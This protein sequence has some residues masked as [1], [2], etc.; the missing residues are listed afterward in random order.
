MLHP[1]LRTYLFREARAKTVAALL[2]VA[3][4]SA[5]FS[6]VAMMNVYL[7]NTAIDRDV[8]GFL[9]YLAISM[10]LLL[11]TQVVGYAMQRLQSR[12]RYGFACALRD[13]ATAVRLIR[14]TLDALSE[15]EGHLLNRYTQD[16]EYVTE[17]GV[18]QFFQLAAGMM[19][20]VASLAAAVWI[21]WVYAIIFPLM[22]GLTMLVPKAFA[23]KFAR[24][25]E[26]YS[27]ARGTLMT[28]LKDLIGGLAIYLRANAKTRFRQEI[29]RHSAEFETAADAYRKKTALYQSVIQGCS[30]FIQVI[31]IIATLVLILYGY[32]T[33]GAIVGLLNLSQSIYSS[34][35][36]LSSSMSAMGGLPPI[37]ARILPAEGTQTCSEEIVERLPVP[38]V[39]ASQIAFSYGDKPVLRDLS[40][41]IAPGEKVAIVGPSG[42]GKSTLLKILL[43]EL[44]PQ[45][46]SIELSG[47][48]LAALSPAQIYETVGFVAQD[49][50]LFNRSIRENITLGED[51]SE[52]AIRKAVSR[53]RLEDFLDALPSGLD[54]VI[55]HNGANVSGGQKQRIVL[56]RE[57]LRGKN[58]LLM[59][60]GTASLDSD[61]KRAIEAALLA[62]SSLTLLYICHP[63]SPEE[64]SAFDHVLRLG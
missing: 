26:F 60:E 16:I 10:G 50:Y 22:M 4:S 28:R 36:Q 7:T 42:S 56:A 14:P 21:H 11:S 34:A 29:N 9:T 63:R 39:H 27:G 31:F 8:R 1:V 44:G 23:P 59:D 57:F 49:P 18:G 30:V 62:D 46:G 6:A 53:A 33:V 48:N 40:F 2:L 45:A 17:L 24:A 51:F 19:M 38:A 12:I 20:I 13:R 32:I 64:L 58:L 43:G 54:T 5:L 61:T 37:F 41:D 35:G 3:L 55:E 52:E 47:Q 25:A 15:N